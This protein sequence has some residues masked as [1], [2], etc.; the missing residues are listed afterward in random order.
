LK[1]FSVNIIG[2]SQKAH[3]FSFILKDAFFRAYQ[4][5]LFTKGDFKAEVSLD[6]HETFIEALFKINGSAEL[7]CDRSLESFEFPV[8]L[9]EKIIFKYGDEEGE[10]SEE[11]VVITRDRVTIDIGQYL[12]EFITL[13]IPMKRLHPRFSESEEEE[14][15]SEGKLVYTSSP[16]EGENDP[17]KPMDPRWEQL[18]KVTIKK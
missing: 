7:I 2:L 12:F 18:K 14:N 15:E 11:I 8:H 6:K 3:H 5:Q 1:D 4:N 17:E 16:L 10:L 13:A 9:D